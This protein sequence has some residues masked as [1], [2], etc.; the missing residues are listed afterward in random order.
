MT[1][2]HS[3]R[4]A[5]ARGVP[6]R[7]EIVVRRAPKFVPFLV[8]GGLLGVLAA[9]VMAWGAPGNPAYDRGTVFGFFAVLLAVPGVVLGGIVALI[10]D[11]MSIKRSERAVVE[12][13]PEDEAGAETGAE[14]DPAGTLAGPETPA[15]TGT[16]AEADPGLRAHRE[17][18]ASADSGAAQNV[19]PGPETGA[20][21]LGPDRHGPDPHGPDPFAPGPE[22]GTNRGD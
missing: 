21:D 13:E 14:A 16:L 11:R 15:E 6:E 7:R 22:D 10:L 2:E 9:A 17:P 5:G 19:V 3:R 4:T 1:S 12:R 18:Q 8:A 20:G